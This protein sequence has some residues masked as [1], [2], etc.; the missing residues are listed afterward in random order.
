MRKYSEAENIQLVFS[1]NNYFELL[2][3]IIDNSKE[4]LHL[5]TY[6]FETDETGLRVINALKRAA[7]RKVQVYI[8]ID[9]FGSNSFSKEAIKEIKRSGIHFRKFSPLFSSESIYFGRRLHYK[10]V[11]ADKQIAIIGGINI[12]NKYNKGT[13]TDPWLD[14]AVLIQGKPC[15]YLNLLCEKAFCK[16][17]D[18]ALIAWERELD[19]TVS[20]GKLIRFRLNDFI[21]GKNEIHNSY[22]EELCRAKKHITIVASYFLPGKGFRKLLADA[23]ARGVSVRIILASQ[24]DVL[25]VRWAENYLYDFLLRNNIHL[26]EWKNSV[27]HGKVMVVDDSWATIGS[28]N[29]NFLSHYISIELNADII[30]KDFI[31]TF[32]LHLDHIIESSCNVIEPKTFVKKNN[33]LQRLLNWLAYIFFRTLMNLTVSKKSKNK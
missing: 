22:V 21:K 14:Y 7:E 5:Q 32:T 29:L 8:L 18:S 16:Q 26:Y 13:K 3:E 30:D 2:E 19:T 33:P 28:Y 23:S 17:K 27:L 4:I 9:A 10:I 6:I 1:G 25:S 20:P 31:Q 11:V 24:S 15:G 12:A